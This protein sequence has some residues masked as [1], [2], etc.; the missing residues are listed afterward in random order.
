VPFGDSLSGNGMIPRLGY[1]GEEKDRENSYV[2][3]GARQYDPAIGRFLS[4][5]PLFEKFTEQTPYQYA[6]NSPLTW[7][8]PSGL[9]PKSEK[10]DKRDR[11]QAMV[12]AD[13]SAG[14]EMA[15]ISN[16]EN[17]FTSAWEKLRYI[18]KYGLAGF[19][20][21]SCYYAGLIS[22]MF[23]QPIGELSFG[24]GGGRTG[25]NK[26]KNGAWEIKNKW[27]ENYIKKYNDYVKEKTDEYV[28]ENKEFTCED[29]AISLII[30]FAAENNLPF[31]FE[32]E[33]ETSIET[34][35]ASDSKWTNKDEFK[36]AVLT[37]AIAE[38]LQIGNNTIGIS[39]NDLNKGDIILQHINP[40]GIAH[41]TQVV[42]GISDGK[43]NVVQ[44]NRNLSS[45]LPN[46][47][48]PASIFY[49]GTKIQYGIYYLSDGNYFNFHTRQQYYS[50]FLQEAQFKRWN[51]NNFNK[52]R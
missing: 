12:L 28:N 30:D 23:N 33:N 45:L 16:F 7:K 20:K 25:E 4:V 47:P 26:S 41:H 35:D 8:D 1:D 11:I 36:N 44:G 50:G 31:R 27:D 2:A 6:F 48:D 9:E 42:I 14:V 13:I 3:M 5:D 37:A 34:F 40:K 51:F 19:S 17:S 43:I 24:G 39:L 52:K 21:E 32:T 18:R 10:R 49:V 38:D 29:L 22:D 46:S 15:N